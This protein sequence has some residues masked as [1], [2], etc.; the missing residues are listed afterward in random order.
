MILGNCKIITIQTGRLAQNCYVIRHIPSG[1][2]LLIDPGA[3]AHLI[4]DAIKREGSRLR[5]ILLTHAHYDHVGALKEISE[6]FEL[7]FFLHEK[8]IKLLNRAP[9]YALAFEK[10]ILKISRNYQFYK[11]YLSSTVGRVHVINLPGHTPGGVCLHLKGFAF[12]GD[13][14]LNDSFGHITDLPGFDA[15]ELDKSITKMFSLLP[16]NTIL[17]PGH[18]KP[19]TVDMAKNCWINQRKKLLTQ[20]EKILYE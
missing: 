3:D 20:S 5:H 11:D 6:K 1:N 2:L 18:G 10:K 7:H 14:L 17:F 8:D 4:L 13:L 9:T 19:W 15:L 12:T 16:A